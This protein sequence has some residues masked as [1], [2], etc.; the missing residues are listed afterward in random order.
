[1]HQLKG[2]IDQLR[3]LEP[4]EPGKVQAVDGGT[5]IESRLAAKPWGPFNSI[6]DFQRFYGYH[7]VYKNCPQYRADFEKVAGRVY[8]TVFTHG[9][10]GPHNILRKDGRIVGVI[11]WETAGWLPEYWEYVMCYFGP[12]SDIPTWWEMFDRIMDSYPDE[13]IVEADVCSI[14]VRA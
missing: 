1:M 3:S 4:P 11:D 6:A 13:L 9:D 7:Y 5:C 2:Y 14:N 12:G 8:R 10:L